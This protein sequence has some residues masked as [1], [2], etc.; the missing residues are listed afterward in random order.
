M[1]ITNCSGPS[2]LRILVMGTSAKPFR[3][4]SMNPLGVPVGTVKPT[5]MYNSIAVYRLENCLHFQI[6]EQS[7]S[8]QDRNPPQVLLNYFLK[9]DLLIRLNQPQ[10]RQ[11]G[12][13]QDRHCPW[14][15]P[16]ALALSPLI[17]DRLM[18]TEAF[19]AYVLYM[20]IVRGPQAQ[21]SSG[22]NSLI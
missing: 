22:I 2:A 3:G 12:A 10:Y 11:L 16:L 21:A 5:P 1:P 13:S 20:S 14:H 7:Q 18:I 9:K 8:K 4:I 19:P 6:Y 17:A 15:W